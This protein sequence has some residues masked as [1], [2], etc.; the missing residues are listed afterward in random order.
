MAASTVAVVVASAEPAPAGT[1]PVMFEV[2]VL[3]ILV[4]LLPLIGYPVLVIAGLLV[5]TPLLRR[6]PVTEAR[7]AAAADDSVLSST[8]RRPS[9]SWCPVHWSGPAAP[10]V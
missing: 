8:L 4:F 5:E 1:G 7:R 10:S 9:G 2:S 6:E 3:E